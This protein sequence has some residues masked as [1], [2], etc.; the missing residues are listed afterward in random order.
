MANNVIFCPAAGNVGANNSFLV[1][2]PKLVNVY[3]WK[4]LKKKKNKEEKGTKTPQKK[5]ISFNLLQTCSQS[6]N[7]HELY[8]HSKVLSL[9][10]NRRQWSLVNGLSEE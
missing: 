10:G 3:K 2:W 6:T 8:C 7:R 1:S 4:R 5:S 9:H